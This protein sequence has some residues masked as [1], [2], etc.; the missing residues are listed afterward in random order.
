MIRTMTFLAVAAFLSAGAADAKDGAWLRSA[1]GAAKNGDV[2]EVPAGNYDLTDLKIAKS[3]T[4]RGDAGGGTFFRSA[5]VT[6]KGILA[7]LPGVD[8]TLENITFSGARYWDRNGAGVR[9][10]GRNLTIVNCRFYNNE[11]GVLATGEAGG[12]VTIRKSVFVG[13]G[14][15]DGMSHGIYLSS[16][17][18]LELTESRFVSTR[19]GPHIKSPADV[20]IVKNNTIDDGVG[21]ASYAVDV[22]KGGDVMIEGN[23]IIQGAD[24]E[25]HTVINY[26]LT[27]GGDAA[28]LVIRGNKVINR[29]NGGVFLRNDTKR[30]PVMS[31]NEF[32]NEGKRALAITS[33]G[34]PRP[35]EQ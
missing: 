22:S 12:A 2:I 1:L 25:N 17:A 27:R 9:H 28:G 15:G 26:D 5:A 33:P 14:F 34:S 23:T 19:N 11:D 10:D 3:V 4:L 7:P 30:A 6:E 21:R 24:A 16:G 35:V 8:L 32:V 31:G 13:N 18:R 29:F 20:T